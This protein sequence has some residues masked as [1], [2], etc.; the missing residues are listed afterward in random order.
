MHLYSLTRLIAKRA[1]GGWAA[2]GPAAIVEQQFRQRHSRAGLIAMARNPS[3]RSRREKRRAVFAVS[4]LRE[5]EAGQPAIEGLL[6]HPQLRTSFKVIHTGAA[7]GG[8][9]A[10]LAAK[11]TSSQPIP[12][13]EYSAEPRPHVLSEDLDMSHLKLPKGVVDSSIT[14]AQ[15]YH[16]RPEQE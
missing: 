6:P 4:S 16:D 14:S 12:L 13:T 3:F 5:V 7:V 9:D 8:I 10:T 11:N 2:V 15:A 1:V